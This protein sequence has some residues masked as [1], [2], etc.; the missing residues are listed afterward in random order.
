MLPADVQAI[1]R[2]P[3]KQ[4]SLQEHKIADD[5]YPV[6]RIDPDKLLAIMP[7]AEGKRYQELRRQLGQ[8]GILRISH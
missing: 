8:L 1:I 6:L 3:E 7:A 4:R 5:Y 2:K